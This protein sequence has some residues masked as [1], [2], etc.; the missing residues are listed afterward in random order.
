MW[1]FDDAGSL[2]FDNIPVPERL[3]KPILDLIIER[4]DLKRQGNA[5]SANKLRVQV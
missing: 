5:T 4:N 2:C 1:S 3:E